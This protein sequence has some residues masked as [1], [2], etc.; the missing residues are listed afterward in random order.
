MYRRATGRDSWDWWQIR[1]D[2]EAL[3][4][5][6]NKRPIQLQEHDHWF[7]RVLQDA[8]HLLM[9]SQDLPLAGD[10][11]TINAYGRVQ[12]EIQGEVSFGVAPA[13]RR[14]GIGRGMLQVLETEASSLGIQRLVA[15]VHPSNEAS[16]RAF[17]RQ[18]YVLGGNPGFVRVEK[19]L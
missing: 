6:N 8:N 10:P 15:Y 16:M 14:Q 12:R 4:W 9:V 7:S 3:F 2:P 13:V 11:H 17:M 18:G 1:N 5:S 19:G